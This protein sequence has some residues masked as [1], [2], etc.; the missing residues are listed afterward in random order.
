MDKPAHFTHQAHMSFKCTRAMHLPCTRAMQE[1]QQIQAEQQNKHRSAGLCLSNAHVTHCH[2]QFH[3]LGRAL[4]LFTQGKH[5]LIIVTRKTMFSHHHHHH[6]HIGTAH[7]VTHPLILVQGGSHPLGKYQA[8]LPHPLPVATQ[9]HLPGQGLL[10]RLL[11]HHP[12]RAGP[13]V[14]GC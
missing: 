11:I 8:P 10:L 5:L 7:N 14:L 3:T 6:H 2:T 9:P 1:Q 4:P 13:R 12:P